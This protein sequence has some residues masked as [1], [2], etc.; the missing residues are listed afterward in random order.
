M[1]GAYLNGGVTEFSPCGN[2]GN[3]GAGGQGV[4]PAGRTLPQGMGQG[5][6]GVVGLCN[7]GQG[8]RRTVVARVDPGLGWGD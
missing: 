8:G 5:C 6:V 7:S 1:G 2:H 4:H 3:S